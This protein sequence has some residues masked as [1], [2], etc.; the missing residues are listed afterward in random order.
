MVGIQ[1]PDVVTSDETEIWPDQR[2]SHAIK[3]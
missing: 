1:I 3:R 2:A